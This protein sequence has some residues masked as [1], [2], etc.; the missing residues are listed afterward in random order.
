MCKNAP[1]NFFKGVLKT[2]KR[3]SLPRG[4]K[5]HS[6]PRP[7]PASDAIR[8]EVRGKQDI[9]SKGLSRESYDGMDGRKGRTVEKGTGEKSEY[10]RGQKINTKLG[11]ITP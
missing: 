7:H 2:I 3:Q 11:S 4:E 10:C 5:A 6:N 9:P 1:S 8:R